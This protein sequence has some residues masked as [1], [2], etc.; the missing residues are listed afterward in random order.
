[1]KSSTSVEE[2]G[3]APLLGTA[4]NDRYIVVYDKDVA[5]TRVK[6]ARKQARA[7]GAKVTTTFTTVLDGFAG[8]LSDEALANLRK[9]PRVAYI[10][11]DRPVQLSNTESPATWGIDR[12]DQRN[13]PLNNSFSSDQTGAGVTAYI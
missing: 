4:S 3:V 7:D 11:P 6:K 5:P 13:L 9:D 1:A 12:I 10:E 8:K 2:P